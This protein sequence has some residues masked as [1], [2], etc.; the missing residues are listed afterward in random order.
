MARML[1]LIKQSAV[2]ANV[3]RS[4]A[5]GAL[6][7]S[8]AEMV[9][10][11]VFLTTNPLF[12]EQAKMT[13]AAWDERASIALCSDPS[14]AWEV[15][16]YFCAP[17]N[18]RPKLVPALLENPSVR[19]ATLQQM[20]Q[21]PL[22]EIVDMM[23]KSPRV[24]ASKDVLHALATNHHLSRE[25][26]E[27]LKGALGNLGEDTGTFEAYQGLESGKTQYEIDHAAEIAAEEGKAFELVGGSLE[28]EEDMAAA[29]A[30]EAA[31]ATAT[32]AATAAATAPALD[33][34]TQKMRVA[35]QKVR[36][37]QSTLQKLAKMSV[38]ERVQQAMKGSKD[39]RYIL[40]RD[41]SKVVSG[42]V[43]Q[44]PKLSDAEVETFAGMKNV[45]E[46]V[47][48]EIA[49]N[50]KFIKNYGVVR[51]L[52]NNPRTPIDIGLPLQNHLLVNDLKA[53]S[54]N[55][56]IG[57]TLRKAALKKY[58]EKSAPAGGKKSE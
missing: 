3:M 13:L 38:G 43:L 1:D 47:L 24:R 4:A 30:A 40:I 51:Q 32:P 55:K 19:E 46:S 14:T 2:P 58:K 28:D 9:E 54:M 6:A 53:L 8:S 5:K 23:L 26:Y 25:E 39:E 57:D 37:R 52:V 35:E 17:E 41:G 10:I 7:L 29:R 44:S 11:L 48:R 31:E 12:A 45:Q 49:R 20:A 50:R 15:L 18:R 36:E 42:A 33:E 34:T 27:E 21:T 56:N 16:Q 22:R